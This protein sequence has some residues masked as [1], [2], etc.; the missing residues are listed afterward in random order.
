MPTRTEKW[1]AG[2]PCWV[3]VAVPDVAEATKFYGPVLGWTFHD[4]G[5]DYGHYTMC[6]AG[7]D[8][9]AAGIGKIQMEGQPAAW[10]VYLASDDVDATAKLIAENGGSVVAGPMDI[11]EVGRMAIAVDPT[12]GV[13]GVWQANPMNGI[14]VY[15]E[16]GGL[17]WEDARLSDADAGKRF[18]STLF[19][20]TYTPIE[21]APDD[22]GTFGFEGAEPL[23]GMGGLMGAPEGT[24]SHWQ[25]YFSV[26]SVDEAIATAQSSGGTVVAPAMD[27]PFGRMATL[28]DPFGA[29]FALYQELPG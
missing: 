24:P 14:V 15:N 7:N 17:V 9:T 8:Q 6:M 5:E 18:Y 16:P 22:Y 12:G 10:T 25:P 11:P 1:P 29:A 3:D 23:G 13:F 19:G 28:L 27:T 21:G 26:T 2:T 20:Y 4:T